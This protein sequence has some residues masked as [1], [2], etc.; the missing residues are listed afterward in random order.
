MDDFPLHKYAYLGNSDV[1]KSYLT[2][3][4][5]ANQLDR[6]SWAPLHYA[7]WYGIAYDF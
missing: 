5:D 4:Y 7:A 6:D 3:G 1:I 2:Q